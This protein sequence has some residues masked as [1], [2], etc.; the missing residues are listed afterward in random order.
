VRVALAS[1]F[2][3]STPYLKR[4]YDQVAAL[5]AELY[6]RPSDTLRC[7]WVEGDSVDGTYEWLRAEQANYTAVSRFGIE[8]DVMLSQHNHGGPKYGSVDDINRW[9]QLAPVLNATLDN[10]QPDDDAVIYVESDLIWD[11][12]TMIRLLNRLGQYPAVGGLI[13]HAAGFFYDTYAYRQNGQR[14][15][16]D[17]LPVDSEPFRVDSIGSCIV[18]RGEVARA[19][20]FGADT[21]LIGESLKAHGYELWVDPTCRIVHP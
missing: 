10:L 7:I 12:E 9:R 1:I 19:C 8:M 15:G 21:C 3:D 17:F 6:R 4:Y 20:R 2:Q 14:F 18:M 16:A 11:A 5:S 13:Y